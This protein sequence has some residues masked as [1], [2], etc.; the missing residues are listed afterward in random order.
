M[1]ETPAHAQQGWD[2]RVQSHLHLGC[3]PRP[4]DL[5]PN[6]PFSSHSGR[7]WVSG[8]GEKGDQEGKP[9]PPLKVG[10]LN[11]VFGGSSSGY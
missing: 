1:R 8:G 2:D 4:V 3:V 10:S 6:I 9:T 5:L 7:N 11:Y